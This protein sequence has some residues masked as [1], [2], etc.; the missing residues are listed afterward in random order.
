MATIDFKEKVKS[1]EEQKYK[2][3]V[4]TVP[5]TYTIMIERK[6]PVLKKNSERGDW[7]EYFSW[8]EDDELLDHELGNNLLF[9]HLLTIL[10]D[11]ALSDIRYM[12]Q[13]KAYVEDEL[14]MGEVDDSHF[15]K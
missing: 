10:N 4:A 7:D 15:N 3:L 8:A 6:K 9:N 14:G 13:L 11:L 5:L 12:N 1:L 2:Q